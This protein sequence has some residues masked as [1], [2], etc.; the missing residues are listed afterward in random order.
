MAQDLLFQ[1]ILA[2]K[3]K[4]KR[5]NQIKRALPLN[6]L[7][8]RLTKQP[9]RPRTRRDP[10]TKI[11]RSLTLFIVYAAPVPRIKQGTVTRRGIECVSTMLT[12]NHIL[13]RP[14]T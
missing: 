6:S 2:P 10:K 4:R 5:R 1:L 12:P 11:L 9:Q 8:R 7:R 13:Q 3:Q 14:L